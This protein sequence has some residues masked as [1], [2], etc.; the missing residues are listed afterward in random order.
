MAA[1]VALQLLHRAPAPVAKIPDY[2]V[3]TFSEKQPKW[4]DFQ[5]SLRAAL[6]VPAFSPD[7]DHLFTTPFNQ[8]ASTRICALILAALEENATT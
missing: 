2:K 6:E 8:A 4:L 5:R 7:S 3:K 1:E